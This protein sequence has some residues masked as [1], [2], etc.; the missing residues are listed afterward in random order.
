MIRAGIDVGGTFTDSVL[1]DEESGGFRLDKRLT[2]PADPCHA[3]LE[4]G[5]T[6]TDDN[7]AALG[8]L[9]QV[10]HATTL[11]T[12][13]LIERKG[14]LTALI[15]T[16]GYRD[17]LEIGRDVRFDLF[18]LNIDRPEPLVPRFLRLEVKERILADGSVREPL[19][20]SSVIAAIESLRREGV[21]SVA[22][23]LLHAYRNSQHERR[24]AELL[25]QELP[26]VSV[27]LSSEVCPEIREF[28]RTGTVAANAY[29]MP[30]AE[31]Y[32]R[33]LDTGLKSEGFRG[34]LSVMNSWGGV[35]AVETAVALPIWLMESGPAAGVAAA[36]AAAEGLGLDRLLSFD[37]GGTTTKI[38]F[39]DD[40]TAS[41]TESFEAARVQRF[42]RGSG[43]LLRV[44]SI[45]LVEIGAGG[46]SIA[47]RDAIG[48]L[49]LGPESAGAD[50]GP[51]CYGQGGRAPTVTDSDLLL[52]HIDP[53]YF[54]GGKMTLDVT[55]AERTVEELANALAMPAEQVAIGIYDVINEQMASAIRVHAS[56][57]GRDPR[58][59]AMMAF[60]GAGPVHG[61]E[62]ARLLGIR[63][64][65]CPVSPGVASAFGLLAAPLGVEIAKSYLAKTGELDHKLLRELV[66]ALRQQAQE[67]LIGAGAHADEITFEPVADVRY[68]GQGYEIPIPLSGIEEQTSVADEVT[69]R[70]NM[71]Y[72]NRFGRQIAGVA[73]E[74][75]TWRMRATAE[76][77]VPL[78]L[79]Q[80]PAAREGSAMKGR[81]QAYFREI[82]GFLECSV[83]DRYALA[84]QERIPGPAMIE[85]DGSTLVVGPSAT[86]EIQPSG[87]LIMEVSQ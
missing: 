40:G 48:L 34:R 41:R 15:T 42:K 29:V 52:G 13:A 38:C 37:M 25:A 64:V 47:R 60:G 12:N 32:L 8:A 46:G 74:V 54:L 31:S 36:A 51:A 19:D 6:L 45:D 82:S 69:R 65:V 81:R 49:K 20:E 84:D 17:T 5:T 7:G 77:P 23:C 56:E 33:R 21:D 27:S 83:Y 71:E 79:M 50:P 62:L 55:A 4:A 2:T 22:V 61:Y 14:A 75:V 39:I 1:F 26:G 53:D 58:D 72:E 16:A 30:L 44:P 63:R 35:M 3:V 24:I 11:V 86:V 59:Y 76:P 57:T 43:L 28:E 80:A 78:T 10:L 85:E 87:A 9:D 66:S 67:V 73:A 68:I 70:F 18:D